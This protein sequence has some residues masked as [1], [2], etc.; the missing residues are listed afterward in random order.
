MAACAVCAMQGDF[1][2]VDCFASQAAA[3]AIILRGSMSAAQT[4]KA[5]SKAIS[6][7]AG[8]KGGVGVVVRHHWYF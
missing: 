3:V 6:E 1:V 2:R 8:R 7:Q 4:S 5:A